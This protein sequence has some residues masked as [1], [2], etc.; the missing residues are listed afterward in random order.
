MPTNAPYERKEGNEGR[1]E[2]HGG[3]SPREKTE[4][5]IRVGSI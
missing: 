2:N 1:H 5:N 3:L 4:K